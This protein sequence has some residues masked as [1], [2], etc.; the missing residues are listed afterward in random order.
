M[1]STFLRKLKARPLLR[2]SWTKWAAISPRKARRAKVA[3]EARKRRRSE[4]IQLGNKIQMRNKQILNK[5]MS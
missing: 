3:R 4:F 1:K 5:S 2:T